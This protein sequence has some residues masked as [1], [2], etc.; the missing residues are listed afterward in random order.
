[1]RRLTLAVSIVLTAAACS[2]ASDDPTT[3]V[4]ATSAPSTTAGS[5]VATTTVAPTSTAPTTTT[6]TTT[7]APAVPAQLTGLSSTLGEPVPIGVSVTGTRR[8]LLEWTAIDGATRYIAIV[9][10]ESGGTLW[11]WTGES[12]SVT[13][14]SGDIDRDG[15]GAFIEAPAWLQVLSV[16]DA[17]TVLG[18]SEPVPVG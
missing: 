6:S 1:M 14:G 4:A 9:T 11:A 18:A 10:D 5:E 13:V 2:G 8:P 7:A 15:I 12:N 16:D 17:G 3:T